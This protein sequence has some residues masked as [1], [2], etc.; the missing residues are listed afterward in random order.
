MSECT[1][2]V[3]STWSLRAIGLITIFRNC[4]IWFKLAWNDHTRF[5][6]W[7]RSKG[8]VGQQVVAKR[9]EIGPGVELKR[10]WATCTAGFNLIITT[11]RIR[12]VLERIVQTTEKWTLSCVCKWYECSVVGLVLLPSAAVFTDEVAK[13]GNL[14]MRE[15]FI[16][17]R[18]ISTTLK[19]E[20]SYSSMYL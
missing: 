9:L 11:F 14:N 3:I 19:G 13:H 7:S 12:G 18:F 10:P 6:L 16:F 2:C 20:W 15:T 4:V 1:N 8:G 5:C 17:V